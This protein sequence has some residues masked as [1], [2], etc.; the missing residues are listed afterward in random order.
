MRKKAIIFSAVWAVIV[1]GLNFVALLSEFADT[2]FYIFPI[3]AAIEFLIIL[4]ALFAAARKSAGKAAKL[5]IF[6]ALLYGGIAV[7]IF[8]ELVASDWMF[9]SGPYWSSY[10]LRF[11]FCFAHF[12]IFA[13]QA[14]QVLLNRKCYG[15]TSRPERTLLKACAL[16]A[17]LLLFGMIFK[18]KGSSHFIGPAL[19]AS[20]ITILV[21]LIWL[22]M[23]RPF[24]NAVV[25]LFFR[26]FIPLWIAGSVYGLNWSSHGGLERLGMVCF[27]LLANIA[28]AGLIAAGYLVLLSE[29]SY[30]A[31]GKDD[32]ALGAQAGCQ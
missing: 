13:V 10:A 31:Q 8:L 1:L 20:V 29:R 7:A 32:S 2:F 6:I 28:M 11:W 21:F 25:L 5:K 24:K 15:L 19:V 4:V 17:L 27:I 14:V 26:I 9:Y 3:A 23:D 30:A 12:L 22:F 16:V 18:G